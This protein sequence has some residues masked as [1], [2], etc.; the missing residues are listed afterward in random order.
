MRSPAHRA[1]RGLLAIV[2]LL[3]AVLLAACASVPQQSQRQRQTATL[4]SLGF[5]AQPDGDW[6]MALPEAISFEFDSDVLRPEFI[7]TV[8]GYAQQLLA[9]DIR[10]L[11]VE[12]HTDNVGAEDYNQALSQRRA[13]AVANVLVDNG[14]AQ[15]DVERIGMGFSHPAASNDTPEG[16]QQNRRVELIVHASGLATQ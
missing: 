13:E 5:T 3:C 16:R 8:A 11:R 6:M 10:T 7:G 12:G 4:T 2:L 14:F 15:R 9:V 1:Q